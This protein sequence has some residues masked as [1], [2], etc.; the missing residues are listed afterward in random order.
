[1]ENKIKVLIVGSD[2]SVK[3]G[4][5]SVIDRFLRYKWN[6]IEIEL[7]PTYIEGSKGKRIVFFLKAIFKYV[8]KVINND[9]DIAHIHMSYNGSFYRKYAIVKVSNAFNKKVILHLHGSEFEVFYKKGNKLVKRLIVDIFEKSDTV[10]V[11]GEKW[12][13]VVKEIAPKSNVEIFNNAVNIPRYKVKWSND[14]INIL[15]LGVLIKRKGIYDLIEA[16]KILNENKII[17][18]KNLNFIIGGSGPEELSLKMKIDEYGLDYCIEMVGWV[19]SDLKDGLLK[20]SQV[21]ILPSYNEGLPM[22]I[23][24]AMSYG[25]PVIATNVGSISEVVMDNKTGFLAEPGDIEKIANY[26]IDITNSKEEWE[27]QSKICKE[28]IY[29]KFN[30]NNYFNN[31]ADMYGILYKQGNG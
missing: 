28:I 23:L 1:M 3:G 16:I 31:I 18:D 13:K 10:I 29:N 9:F 15:F 27:K 19:N 14:K 24:E 7:L 22:A 11:L 5:T 17:K 26:I 4:I 12:N 8:K 20:K 6:N 21:F 2:L 30:E 25:I